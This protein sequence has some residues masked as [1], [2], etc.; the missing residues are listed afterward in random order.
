MK[1]RWIILF[2]LATF[3][4]CCQQV[5][6]QELSSGEGGFSVLMPGKPIEEMQK[7]N[8][9]RG[10]IGMHIFTLKR[11][12]IAYAASYNDY[13]E[14]IARLH[15]AEKMLTGARDGVISSVRGKLLSEFIISIGTYPGREVQIA[16]GDGKYVMRTRFYLVKNRLYQVGVIT[17][18]QDIYSKN[19]TK[20]FESFKLQEK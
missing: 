19:V 4:M 5:T 18:K 15:N 16:L 6:W 3:L 1:K 9:Q 14:V 13:P 11:K 10:V 20:Y 2:V 17:P 7:V 12:G 8:T